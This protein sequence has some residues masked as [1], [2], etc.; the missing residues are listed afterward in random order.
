MSE[1]EDKSMSKSNLWDSCETKHLV[2][3]FVTDEIKILM[4][5]DFHI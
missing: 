4:P 1:M 3:V 2:N 5:F